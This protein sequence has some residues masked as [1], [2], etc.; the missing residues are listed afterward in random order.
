MRPMMRAYAGDSD[1]WRVRAFLRSLLLRNGLHLSMW[2]VSRWDYWRWHVLLNCEPQPMEEVVTLCE[3]PDGSLAAVLNPDNRGD[4][5]FQVD[6]RH[7][8]A[9]DREILATA[10]DRLTSP[11]DGHLN[12]W[13]PASDTAWSALLE[14]TGYRP[15]DDVEHVRAA[16][17]AELPVALPSSGY[18]I[19]PVTDEDFPAR[20]EIS[21]RVFHPVPDGNIAMTHDE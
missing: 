2:H 15:S 20:G 14:S 3:A 7:R 4:A 5:F 16:T 21:L 19:R 17:L 11:A 12:V 9:L 10:E 18:R 13:T 6:P 1:Y 8:S